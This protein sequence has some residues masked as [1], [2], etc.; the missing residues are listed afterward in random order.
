MRVLPLVLAFFPSVVLADD[1]TL[2]S[3]VT[4][5]L[6]YPEGA[7]ITRVV[8]FQVPEGRHQLRLIDLPAGTPMEAV[9][10]KVSGVAMGAVTLRDN[11]V[12]PAEDRESDALKAARDEVERL[13][14]AVRA[15]EDAAKAIRAAGE[16]ADTRITFLRQLGQGEALSG[17]GTDVLRD[18]SR[19]VG[20][21]TLAARQA[22]LS[23]EGEARKVDREVEDLREALEKA[24]Q[25]VRALVPESEVR[26][27]VAVEVAAGAA[28]E[29]VM[30]V[31]YYDWRASWM[32]V[33]D[34]YLDRKAG[35]VTLKRGVLVAQ[36]TGENWRDVTLEMSTNAP[37]GKVQPSHLWPDKRRITDPEKQRA[38]MT[39]K[40]YDEAEMGMMADPVIEAPVIVEE[41][42][43][44]VSFDGLSVTYTYPEKINLASSADHVR[45]ALGEL[46]FDAEVKAQAVPKYDE[47]AFLVAEFTNDSPELILP[48]EAVQ[49]FRDGAYV[50]QVEAHEPIPTGAE[51][52]LAFGPIE[53][54]RLTRVV[55]RNQGERGVLSTSHQI[56]EKVRIEA[57]N[58]TGD[59][60][61][62]R[63][64][65]QV[66][67]SEQ[68]DLVIT[69]NAKPRPAELDVDDGK[70]IMAW[71]AEL[72]PGKTMKIDLNYTIDWPDGKVLR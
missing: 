49:L 37:E 16:A 17:A 62:M 13:Q 21:E 31:S 43:A 51:A 20:E 56:A 47:T 14:E 26:N 68:E 45:L 41:A 63:V 19:M 5:V 6:M 48:S 40:R 72:A 46:G 55:D 22:A 15:K 53:G 32:P 69:W 10:V 52:M 67:Y 23:A 61:P 3:K 39:S 8:P 38:V 50:G 30:E 27:L 28:T 44:S 66:P 29:G 7:K 9:R 59:T 70:G 34:A 1:I 24:K 2:T 57:E 65:D 11:Y 60:W 71:E 35:Q 18:V 58:L 42:S 4:D 12:P 25:A 54:L 33:Y 36:N 64:I